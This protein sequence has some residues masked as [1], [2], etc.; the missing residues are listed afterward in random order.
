M[1][2]VQVSN[3]TVRLRQEYTDRIAQ[4][5]DGLEYSPLAR[6]WRGRLTEGLACALVRALPRDVLPPAV[7]EIA[8]RVGSWRTAEIA[9]QG[10]LWH[11]QSRGI[12]MI[13]SQTAGMLAWDMGTG[14][15][16]AVV[17]ALK[18]LNAGRVLVLAPKSVVPVWPAELERWHSTLY[19]IAL[20][21]G[22][23]A[24]RATR[25]A[26][27]AQQF[28]RI[29]AVLNYEAVLREGLLHAVQQ[30]PWDVLV[31][32]ESH[33]LKSPSGRI[34]H[35]VAALARTIP[36]RVFLTGTPMPHSPLDIYAQFRALD[37]AVLGRSFVR[38]RARYAV[39]GGWQN[40]QVLRFTNLDELEQRL[41]PWMYRISRDQVLD[42]PPQVWETRYCDPTLEALVLS[43][44]LERELIAEVQAGA[45]AT[46]PNVLV[47]LLRQQQISSGFV[48]DDRGECN[49][50]GTWK[51][52]ALREVLDDLP[53]QEP[54]VVFARFLHD[55]EAIRRTAWEAGRPCSVL[56]GKENDVGPRWKP[57]PGEVAA[58][59]IHAGGL[60]IDLS[61]AATAVYYSATW[62][63]GDWLQSQARLHRFGQQR[64]VLFIKLVTRGIFDEHLYRALERRQHIVDAV[65]EAIRSGMLDQREAPCRTT[66]T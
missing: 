62:D 45:V 30:V 16:R 19:A 64:H 20:G 65:L 60:G 36:R 26:A 7:V 21:S 14:K 29:A 52:D 33:R 32:D 11:H 25:L 42:L 13:C 63:G 49:P 56:T 40:R 22:D 34:S 46:A 27:A 4:T 37:P 12:E 48:E 38:F 1:I 41:A 8:E 44:T 58:I 28:K 55:I 43:Q 9:P 2:A 59:Q 50:L 10:G 3:G 39:M 24:I 23:T 5:I 61:A 15:T 6:E 17:E 51:A 47:R 54:V 66:A 57:K 18:R 53:P 31:C 35:V